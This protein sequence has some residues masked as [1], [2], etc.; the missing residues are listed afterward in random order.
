M[1]LLINDNLIW[2][3]TPK[4]ASI[5]IENALYSS[6][7]NIKPSK[8]IEINNNRHLHIPIDILK[9]EFG[10]KESICI[11]RD[12]FEKWLSA[13]NHLWDVINM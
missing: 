2:V 13:L 3:A 8:W 5:S 4:C 9:K 7:L 11:T 6:N 12:W 1:S 10:N